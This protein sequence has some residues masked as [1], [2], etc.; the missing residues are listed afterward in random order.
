MKEYRGIPEDKL[1][2]LTYDDVSIRVRYADRPLSRRFMDLSTN[3][4]P[5][6]LDYPIISANMASVTELEMAKTLSGL[7]G[8][9]LLHR[10]NSIHEDVSMFKA[11][12]VNN[13]RK[14]HV[15]VSMGVK[16]DERERAECLH[17]AGARTFCIDIAHGAQLAMVKQVQWFRK[18][19]GDEPVLIV[20]NFESAETIH[21][22]YK[23][24]DSQGYRVD[25]YKVGIGPGAACSTR[26]KTGVGTPQFSAVLD[27]A[28]EFNVIADG[29]CRAPHHVCKA[30][31]A[32][33]QAAMLGFMLA[34]TDESPGRIMV[35]N[36]K[37]YKVYRGSA[38]GGF[39]SGWK[40]S[41]GVRLE[42]PYKGPVEPIIFDIEGGL[43]SSMGYTASLDLETYR[44]VTEFRVVS[45]NAR[46]EAA[47]LQLQEE[48]QKPHSEE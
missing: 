43:R 25:A 20:G 7:G 45:A 4:G 15:G 26:I 18:T 22:V 8:L 46:I 11:A 31:A 2:G 9:A 44:N 27:C 1:D 14:D 3:I 33:A 19:F 47:P 10:F 32:G 37:K 5:L 36:G 48:K 39:A 12:T 41:E 34:G 23:R 38:A 17:K 28:R 40:T 29:G 24:C 21:E 13:E 6:K 30:L 16:E 42:I 35:K